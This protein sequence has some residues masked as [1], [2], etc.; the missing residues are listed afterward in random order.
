MKTNA[1]LILGAASLLFLVSCGGTDQQ[2]ANTETIA[3]TEADEKLLK[4]AQGFFKPLPEAKSFDRPIAE[5]GK[6]LYYE[7]ALSINNKLS[8]NTCHDLAKFGV[9]HEATSAGHE[10]VRG[11][12]NSPTV[13]NAYF[14]IAQFWDGRAADL[15]EQAKGPILNPV[16]MGMPHA[17]SVE[18]AIVALEDY[19]PLFKKVFPD[20][21]NPITFDNIALAIAEFEHTLA[22]PAP[23]DDYLHGNISALSERQRK[24]LQHFINSGCIT[25]HMGPGLGG[26]M[27]HKFGLINGPYWEYTG[28]EKI[29]NGRYDVT[30]KE[31]DK[32]FFKVPALRNVTETYPY[33]HDGSVADLGEAVKIMAKTQVGRDLTDET[34]QEIVDF[35]G[36]LTGTIPQHALLTSE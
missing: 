11:D 27:Y 23:F 30:G 24:G 10:D 19:L 13:Y 22:T 28:S 1:H 36:S 3:Y 32:Y 7:T 34:V 9:D 29:D 12:R 14:H 20:D 8:C 6:Q 31:S 25:C 18:Q 33:F 4:Q 35:L 2:D 17:M 15:F 16:E 26:Q 5:L 21:N